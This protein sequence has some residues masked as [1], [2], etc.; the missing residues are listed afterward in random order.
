MH[1]RSCWSWLA[2]IALALLT[3]VPTAFADQAEGHYRMG[4]NLKKKGDTAAALREVREAV[5]LR[6]DHAAAWMTL[7]GLLRDQ[8]DLPG[9]R[10]A[11]ERVVKLTP[12]HAPAY[13]L[14]GAVMV[15]LK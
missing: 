14:G 7:G 8:G 13:A 1:T 4:L 2:G 5:K 6:P 15:R 12:T 3:F 9:S 11:F 10:D